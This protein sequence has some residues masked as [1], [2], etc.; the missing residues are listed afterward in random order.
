MEGNPPDYFV[1]ATTACDATHARL[2]AFGE[3][4]LISRAEL[5]DA[6]A[7]HLRRGRRFVSVDLAG[8]TFLDAAGIGAFVAAH[9]RFLEAHGQLV[10]RNA[11]Q[12]VLQ[13]L[14]LVGVEQE[15]F[16]LDER[17]SFGVAK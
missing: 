9:Q 13:L 17:H 4:D 16:L 3:L 7:Y 1:L 8:L 5:Q 12:R 14:G 15:L 10:F 11:P 2:E 6:L